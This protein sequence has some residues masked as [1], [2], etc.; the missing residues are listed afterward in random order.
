MTATFLDQRPK[1]GKYYE[2][3]GLVVVVR[4]TGSIYF[5]QRYTHDGRRFTDALGSYPKVSLAEAREKAIAN[6]R[7][8][9]AGKDPIT[10][11]RRPPTPTLAEAC[12]TV[13]EERKAS[14]SSPKTA[15]LRTRALEKHIFPTLGDRLVSGISTEDLASLLMPIREHAPS[16]VRRLCHVLTGVMHWAIV[17]DFR[18]DNP[19]TKSLVRAV[20]R[21]SRRTKHHAALPH[22]DVA[23]ALAAIRSS[24][25]WISIRLGL[26]FLILTAV[27]S[28]EV[29]GA[30]WDEIDIDGALWTIPAERMKTGVEHLVP[31]VPQSGPIFPGR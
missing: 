23:A 14:W 6:H 22:A 17:S 29:R 5:E 19:V 24:D 1:P 7:L 10:E 21:P 28:G 4:E 26:E 8:V 2:E 9:R 25:A 18:A 11:K 30:V 20:S 16:T 31:L 3:H 12:A 27:R 15:Q 13:I